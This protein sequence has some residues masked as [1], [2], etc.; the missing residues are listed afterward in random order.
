MAS[1]LA[2]LKTRRNAVASEL[3]ALTSVTKGGGINS[4]GAGTGVDHKGYKQS[5]YDELKHLDEL[6]KTAELTDATDGDGLFEESMD[7]LI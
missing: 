7:M 6:I 4:S 1:Y 3:A 5:L 2:D